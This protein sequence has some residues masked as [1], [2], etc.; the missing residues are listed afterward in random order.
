MA[1]PLQTTLPEIPS[2]MSRD[3]CLDH[4][5]DALA[6][7]AELGP[8]GIA[9][10]RRPMGVLVYRLGKLL[11]AQAAPTQPIAA[12]L[13]QDL[14]RSLLLYPELKWQEAGLRHALDVLLRVLDGVGRYVADAP[15]P[16]EGDAAGDTWGRPL[17]FL[18]LFDALSTFAVAFP[19]RPD[20]RRYEQQPGEESVLHAGGD[21]KPKVRQDAHRSFATLLDACDYQ[22]GWWNA[23]FKSELAFAAGG[24]PY[25]GTPLPRPARKGD[26]H[27]RKPKASLSP[28]LVLVPPE[29]PGAHPCH[30]SRVAHAVE[31]KLTADSLGLNQSQNHVDMFGRDRFHLLYAPEL[32][33]QAPLSAAELERWTA[34]LR[35]DAGATVTVAPQHAAG[36]FQTPA[37][38]R[39]TMSASAFFHVRSKAD[40]G[41]LATLLPQ[42]HEE[43]QLLTGH[44]LT[45][46]MGFRSGAIARKGHAQEDIEAQYL[47][48]AEDIVSLQGFDAP[49]KESSSRFEFQ[50]LAQFRRARLPRAAAGLDYLALHFPLDFWTARH[51]EVRAWWLDALQRLQPVQAYM[52]LGLGRPPVLERYPL[53]QPAE[54]ALA[55]CFLGLDVDKPFFMR[56]SRPDGMS[57]ECGMRTP[58]FGVL[59]CGAFAARL[60]G[61]DAL[62]RR[63]QKVPGMRVQP[64]MDGGGLWI[65]AGEAPALYPVE[66]GA[67]RHLRA[68]A[69]ALIPVRLDRLWMTSYPPNAASDGIFTPA[70]SALWLQRFDSASRWPSGTA[71]APATTRP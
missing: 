4:I 3:P 40:V 25:I 32:Q 19:V 44:A 9:G 53:Q 26:C 2:G 15:D 18:P 47:R 45:R 21:D 14:A 37:T 66:D 42:L 1:H 16:Q 24:M 38:W 34:A 63:L 5:D 46:Y 30:A 51:T 70:S 10:L 48:H 49:T 55:R 31:L 71:A 23:P 33:G 27:W 62:Q 61:V 68:L 50:A 8:D 17:P 69:E 39:L 20:S 28:D 43:F 52:G 7:L 6:V 56:S 22:A 67:P 58:G 64:C 35:T 11:C 54:F 57:L 13:E 12:L 41:R 29:Q 60:G 65:E 36:L 59:V